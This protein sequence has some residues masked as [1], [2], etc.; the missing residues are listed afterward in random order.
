MTFVRVLPLVVRALCL[1]AG[2]LMSGVSLQAAP[3][4]TVK[5]AVFPF[6]PAIFVDEADG[7]VKGFYVD[8]LRE[9][10]S[11][12]RWELQFVQGTWAEGLERARKGEVD[13]LTSVAFT[14]E[15]ATFLDYGKEPSF[16]V[17]SL[18]Y[19]HPKSGIQS[20][21]D[22]KDRSVAVMRNDANGANFRALATQ[23]AIP[24]TFLELGSFVDVMKAVESRQVEAGVT[25]NSF[26]YFSEHHYRVVRTPVVVNPFSLFFAVGK[27]KNTDLLPALDRFLAENRGTPQSRHAQ[28]V[29]R[30]LN[31]SHGE[32][33]SPWVV[34]GFLLA[35]ALLGLSLGAVVVFRRQVHRATRENP[36]MDPAPRS[37]LEARLASEENLAITLHSIGDAVIATDTQ[38]LITRMNATAER[39]TG[40]PLAEALGQPLPEVFRIANALT[41][42]QS[43]DPVQKVLAHG[44][45]VGLANH[46]VLLARDDQ[47]YQIAD[48]AAP[49]RD[50]AGKILGVVLVFSDVTEK[51]RVEEALARTTDLLK[52]ATEIAKI[53]AWELELAS[54]KLTWSPG[55][56]RLHELDPQTPVDVSSGIHFY[57]PEAQ[58]VIAAAVQA[59]IETGTP[60]DLELPLLTAKGRAFWARAQ[61]NPV[62]ENGKVIKLA[63]AFQDITERKQAEAA[64]L[65]SENRWKFAIEGAGDGLWDWNVQTGMAYFSSRYKEM[66]GYADADIGTTSDEWSKRIH[67]DDAPGVFAALQPYM[68]GKPGFAMVEFR[69]LCK[70][71]S[72]RW[73]LGRGMVISRDT[74]G[75][76]TR[77]IGINTDIS[78]RKQA[79]ETQKESNARFNAWFNLPIIGI[80]ITS[81]TKG[82]LEVN[83]HLC[84]LLG[85]GRAELLNLTWADLT[86]P[87]DLT[88]DL[89]QFE[90]VRS[91]EIEGYSLEKRFLRKDGGVL[92]S[93]LS[94]RCVRRADGSIDYF[95][96]LI[97]DMTDR[98]Q[99]DEEKHK[100]QAQL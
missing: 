15:S 7:A 14:Q 84:F 68:E 51:Y 69:M 100:L 56:Y 46:T 37:G 58:P 18:L 55:T 38:G 90:R 28:I 33:L 66:Y 24:I 9:V 11:R 16:T 42:E 2:L 31:R 57:A 8:M 47:E 78:A 5:V 29:D 97:Q 93:H 32:P 25:P 44:K 77:M 70:D 82:W 19:A 30:W 96:A 67:P 17:W 64:L 45:V 41:R 1:A 10:A 53:G 54:M 39:L 74:E 13:L 80:C 59:A 40:W 72:W 95:V 98:K 61:C 62:I 27:G 99:A 12:E 85:Y 21:L 36:H 87:E 65:E 88:A 86:H 76:P 35:L 34:W 94:V 4:R 50:T 48:S 6:P 79:E 71:G 75:K 83:D 52:S 63:G 3:V 73:T 81:L 20:I 22:L 91:G 23:F 60:Y 92:H 89:A 43:E 26:G 49:I